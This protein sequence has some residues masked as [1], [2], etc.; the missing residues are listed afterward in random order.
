MLVLSFE[1]GSWPFPES[2]KAT[3]IGN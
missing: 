1:N 2:A 3:E